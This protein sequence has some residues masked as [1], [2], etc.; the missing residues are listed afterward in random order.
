MKKFFIAALAITTLASCTQDSVIDQN[1][2]N[3]IQFSNVFV[4]NSTR[5][6]DPSWSND[7]LFQDFAV[8]GFVEE[9]TLFNGV[10]VKGSGLGQGATWTYDNT[11]YW[12][13]GANYDFCAIAPFSAAKNVNTTVESGVIVTSMPFANTDGKLDLVYSERN[14]VVGQLQNNPKVAFTFRHLLSRIRFTF[15]S[16]YDATN[17]TIAVNEVKI[18]NAHAKGT[19]SLTE[20]ATAWTGQANTNVTLDFGNANQTAANPGATA[21]AVNQLTNGA[22]ASAFNQLLVIP[23]NATYEIT[24][25]VALSMNGEV[26]KTYDHKATVAIDAQP[27]H[28]YNIKATIT[29]QNIDPEHEQEPIEFTVE[30]MSNWTDP[31]VDLNATI[32]DNTQN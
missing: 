10:Q 19:V 11:Q 12:V 7:N 29:P 18:T 14:N 16:A 28:S 31:E 25:K 22:Q 27:A 17:A 32:Q 6:Y 21:D 20:G 9:A 13:A 23:A 8:Y 26:I 30:T 5:A 24:F 15:T 1:K 4:D 2:N 3:T